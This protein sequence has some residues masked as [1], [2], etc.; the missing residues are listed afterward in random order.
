MDGAIESINTA[1]KQEPQNDLYF[2]TA[3]HL[4]FN[5][6]KFLKAYTHALRALQI[7]QVGWYNIIAARSAFALGKFSESRKY[8]QQAL[9]F[10]TGV[11][12]N[13]NVTTAQEIAHQA[14]PYSITLLWQI[15]AQRLI[16]KNGSYL[17][18]VAVPPADMG[19]QKTD[20]EARNARVM[21]DY[22]QNGNRLLDLISESG[23]SVELTMRIE[24]HPLSQALDFSKSSTKKFPDEVK[25]YLG[26]SHKVDLDSVLLKAIDASV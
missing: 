18:T 7:K 4:E 12:G 3:A 10:G 22:T 5:R 13:A 24:R 14:E 23:K 11:L 15:P 9:S 6:G 17:V 26:P 19:Y 21:R 1:L 8:A 20:I 2:A 16:Q 25:L